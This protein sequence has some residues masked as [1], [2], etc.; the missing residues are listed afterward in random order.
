MGRCAWGRVDLFFLKEGDETMTRKSTMPTKRRKPAKKSQA[1]AR[2][3]KIAATIEKLDQLKPPNPKA[4]K[5]IALLKSWL[6]DE[7]GYDEETWPK[8]S[9]ALRI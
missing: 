1:E 5:V 4:A 2:R 9:A 7:S 8:L 3:Q 6:A